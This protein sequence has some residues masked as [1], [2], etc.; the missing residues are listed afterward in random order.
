MI[1]HEQRWKLAL[2]H[3]IGYRVFCFFFLGSTITFP[4]PG[5]GWKV[6]MILSLALAALSG[7][8]AVLTTIKAK[9]PGIVRPAPLIL[10][11]MILTLPALFILRK[12]WQRFFL[13]WSIDCWDGNDRYFFCS[14]LLL[15]VF[16]GVVYESMFRPWMIKRKQRCE[17]S[18]LI[19]LG[20]LTLHGVGFRLNGWQTESRWRDYAQ[21]IH[22]AEAR[23][24]LTGNY[25]V[26][27]INAAP[28]GFDFD[29]LINKASA[30]RNN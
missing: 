6:A 23:V 28:S 19:L 20:W 22:D 7:S 9:K 25:E 18:L 27:H 30:N 2:L 10:F 14:T 8:V 12:E 15:G 13:N 3:A 16:C 29:L 26:V 4:R 17:V 1:L 5:E 11:Y 21:K 24:K